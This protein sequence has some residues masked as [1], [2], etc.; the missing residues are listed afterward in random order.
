MHLAVAKVDRAA[1][2]RAIDPDGLRS[3]EARAAFVEDEINVVETPG[4][5]MVEA[6]PYV[7]VRVDTER[8]LRAA[9]AGSE[10]VDEGTGCGLIDG[11]E[12]GGRRVG[13]I[14]DGSRIDVN[15]PSKADRDQ[16]DPPV[17]AFV[18]FDNNAAAASQCRL[19]DDR[20][21]GMEAR[22]P[23]DGPRNGNHHGVGWLR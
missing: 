20:V 4:K 11:A 19:I 14:R 1:H 8:V 18:R 6:V 2:G 5:E 16:E 15:R 17:V 10:Y 12:A 13:A 21:N 3:A 23:G 9:A 7:A 22:G